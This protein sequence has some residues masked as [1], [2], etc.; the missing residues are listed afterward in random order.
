MWCHHT[1]VVADLVGSGV[2]VADS[3]GFGEA[4]TDSAESYG[5]GADAAGSGGGRLP[6]Q[7]ELVGAVADLA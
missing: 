3:E 6:I 7:Q 1:V 4:V 5:F 2:V